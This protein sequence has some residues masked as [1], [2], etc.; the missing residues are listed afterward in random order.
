MLNSTITIYKDCA[1]TPSKN[2][3]VDDIE[4]YLSTLTKY[5]K[6]DFQYIKNA[7][8]ITIKVDMS[9]YGLAFDSNNLNYIKVENDETTTPVYYFIINKKWL[10]TSTWELTLHMDSINSFTENNAFSWNPKTNVIREH[11][12]RWSK[13]KRT[14]VRGGIIDS[15]NQLVDGEQIELYDNDTFSVKLGE[16]VIYKPVYETAVFYARLFLLTDI[17]FEPSDEFVI[18]S[19]NNNNFVQLEVYIFE[20][21]SYYQPIV[22]KEIEGINP[23]LFKQREFEINDKLTNIDWYLVY[24][25]RNIP[26][27]ENIDNPVDCYLTTNQNLQVAG[28][29]E[30]IIINSSLLEEN[31]YYFIPYNVS[32]YDNLGNFYKASAS[33]DL[34][35]DEST[36]ITFVIQKHDNKIDLYKN[37]ISQ[38]GSSA[39]YSE[40]IFTGIVDNIKLNVSSLSV[41]IRK[42]NNYFPSVKENTAPISSDYDT[43]APIG[44]NQTFSKGTIIIGA[45]KTIYNIDRTDS[46]L[47]KIIKLPYCPSQIMIENNV[48]SFS[49]NEWIFDDNE[50]L[51]KLE[52]LSLKFMNQIVIDKDNSPLFDL[53]DQ[54]DLLIDEIRNDRFETKLLNSEFYNPVIVYDSFR[55]VFQLENV[56]ISKIN[57]EEF[58]IDFITTSTIN[59]KFMFKFIDYKCDEYEISDFNNIMVVARSNEITLYNSAYINYIK[60]GF[61]YD[62]KT[63]ER[64]ETLNWLGVGLSAVGSAVAFASSVFTGG[65]GVAAGV[66]LATTT[67]SHISNAIGRQQELE[68]NQSEKLQQLKAQA[69]SISG[70]DD[71]DLMS[72]YCNNKA[73]VMFYQCS[74]KMRRI[75]ADLFYYNGYATNE[76]KIPNLHTRKWFNYVMCDMII[77]EEYNLTEEIKEDLKTKYQIGVTILHHV[78]EDWDFEQVKENWE[79]SII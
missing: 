64:T 29:S 3:R 30:D 41:D 18:K 57:F 20:D 44:T 62:V 65:A 72:N 5:V 15:L 76:L 42:C 49:N 63:K 75:V 19:K 53:R 69:V 32:F 48:I 36:M 4:D 34:L 47:I 61:N 78:N 39:Q 17:H 10:S 35:H 43:Y 51:L 31:K 6:E 25:N 59:S 23:L 56:S 68:Q 74:E 77:N 28:K 12:D 13:T 7:V 70:S 46:K 71:V 9:Q 55:F 52:D 38:T 66:A 79:V 24:K 2:F 73:K 22:D 60:N 58:H 54:Y 37:Y 26:S 1:I 27:T 45:L 33:F 14:F 21:D 50:E 40:L 67:I 11:K 16:G 8:E